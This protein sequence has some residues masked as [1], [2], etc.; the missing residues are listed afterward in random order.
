MPT[1]QLALLELLLDAAMQVR[2]LVPALVR[3]CRSHYS[4]AIE[5][6][7][8]GWSGSRS[9]LDGVVN[10]TNTDCKSMASLSDLSQ[11]ERKLRKHG[12]S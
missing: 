5:L 9:L 10:R 2:E 8:H 12:L 4:N 6:S 11:Y 1:S 3:E 7:Y